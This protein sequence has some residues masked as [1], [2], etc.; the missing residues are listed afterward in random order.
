MAIRTLILAIATLCASS[1]FAENSEKRDLSALEVPSPDRGPE[2]RIRVGVLVCQIE[3]GFGLLLGSS[4]P[5][6]CSFDTG[7]GAESYSGRISKLGLDVGF[8]QTQYLR[9]VVFAPP[10]SNEESDLSGRY[11]GV[12]AMSTLGAGFGANALVGGSADRII[13]QPVSLQ[14]GK[15]VNVAVGVASMRLRR[16]S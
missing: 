8:T 12:S 2:G 11:A 6:A 15:G 1:A 13:L 3:G 4:K 5:V 9:W 7:Y 14:A 10:I 16:E